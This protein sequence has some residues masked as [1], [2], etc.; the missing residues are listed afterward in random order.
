MLKRALILF[1]L[2]AIVA[3]PFLLRPKQ[4]RRE[5]ADET[6]TLITPHNEAIRHEFSIG[7]QLWYKE[8]T[9]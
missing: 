5:Q 9:G 8:L 1:V 2:L 7:L 3:L 6:L 4:E